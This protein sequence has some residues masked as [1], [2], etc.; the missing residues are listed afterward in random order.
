MPS[1]QCHTSLLDRRDLP[2]LF[3]GAKEE[4]MWRLEQTAEVWEPTKIKSV[5]GQ[6]ATGLSEIK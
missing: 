3:G 5:T 2:K 6:C 1:Y 4:E